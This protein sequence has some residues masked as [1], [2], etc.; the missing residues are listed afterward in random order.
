MDETLDT[1][2]LDTLERAPTRVS[3]FLQATSR[4]PQVHG[5]LSQR[6]YNHA[7]HNK[8]AALLAR[9]HELP[10]LDALA[11]PA[12]RGAILELDG[13][14]EPNFDLARA[15]LGGEFPAVG[16][17]VFSNLSAASGFGAVLS[18]QTFLGRLEQVEA[19][20][21]GTFPA[22]GPS[23]ALLALDPGAC[24]GA[25]ALLAERGIT[26]QERDRLKALL[27]VALSLPETD[28]AAIQAQREQRERE[29]QDLLL[30]LHQWWLQASAI[31]RVTIKRRDY[32]VWL[33]L[34]SRRPPSQT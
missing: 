4:H 19:R 24:A 20:A 10:S 12:A 18:V 26:P 23:E 28:F 32:L 31:A 15:A 25:L 33:G 11:Q 30:Q 16:R 21:Q 6:G 14:D 8:A 22:A 29:V 2:S 27:A 9:L 5:A 13:W 34:A 3:T 17:Y 7:F 1:P